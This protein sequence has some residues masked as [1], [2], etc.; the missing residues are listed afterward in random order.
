ML[1]ATFVGEPAV[2]ILVSAVVAVIAWLKDRRAIAYAQ[3]AAIAGFGFNTLLKHVIHRGRPSTMYAAHMR[4]HSYSFPSGHAFGSVAFYG[5]WAYLLYK[6]LPAP[7]NLICLG[8]FIV[9]I[10]LIGVSRVYLGAHY[11]SD[12]LAGWGIGL[13]VLFLIIKF[14]RP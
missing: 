5:L 10:L 14:I 12:V 9:L 2:I 6:Y 11:P 13:V 7:W 8:L 1:A 3:A 4:I